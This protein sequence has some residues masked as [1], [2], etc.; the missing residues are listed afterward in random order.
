MTKKRKQA[1]GHDPK[2]ALIE[3][4]EQEAPQEMV[5]EWTRD[6]EDA[7]DMSLIVAALIDDRAIVRAARWK[8]AA[9]QWRAMAMATNPA[10]MPWRKFRRELIR[11]GLQE[12]DDD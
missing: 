2:L 5:T 8:A 12:K 4:I 9:T 7:R 1:V 3:F 6:C 10:S 11:L